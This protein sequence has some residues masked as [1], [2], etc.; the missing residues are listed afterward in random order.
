M[1]IFNG[2][3]QNSR[4]T[5]NVNDRALGYAPQ[6]SPSVG[7]CALPWLVLVFTS[8]SK[9]EYFVKSNALNTDAYSRNLLSPIRLRS[10]ERRVGKECVSTCRSRWSRVD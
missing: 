10:E 7:Y 5:P 3:N 9:P 4:F 8:G 6:S 1:K 2:Y